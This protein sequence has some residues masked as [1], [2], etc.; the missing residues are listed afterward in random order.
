MAS[1]ICLQV[2]A[3]TNPGFS[4]YRLQKVATNSEQ[5]NLPSQQQA[6]P[7]Q[8]IVADSKKTQLVENTENFSFNN[9]LP[10]MILALVVMGFSFLLFAPA[11][12]LYKEINTAKDPNKPVDKVNADEVSDTEDAYMASIEA[13]DELEYQLDVE[14][15]LDSID[16][17]IME[18]IDTRDRKHTNR[19]ASRRKR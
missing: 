16:P 9:N 19:Y 6:I 5:Q 3:N 15:E 8:T 4:D 18:R 11:R 12:F 7:T 10:L 2:D 1:S 14:E 13:E 17:K